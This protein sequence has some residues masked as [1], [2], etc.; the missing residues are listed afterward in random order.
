MPIAQSTGDVTQDEAQQLRDLCRDMLSMLTDL[1]N[2][3]GWDELSR[4][5]DDVTD[6]A[7]GLCIEL[8]D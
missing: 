6:D 8:D 5:L 1:Q 7:N 3:F 2:G 4:R